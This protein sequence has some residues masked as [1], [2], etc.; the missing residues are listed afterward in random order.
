MNPLIMDIETL[1]AIHWTMERKAAYNVSKVPGN[2]KKPAT[3]QNWMATVG[4]TK[5]QDTSFSPEH[6]R[7]FCFGHRTRWTEAKVISIHH[8]TD[9]KELIG[10]IEE[11]VCTHLEQPDAVLVAHNGRSFD[12]PFLRIR[13]MV[14][15][16]H[17]LASALKPGKPWA[18]K[19]VDTC[20]TFKKACGNMTVSGGLTDMARLLGIEVMPTPGCP[21]GS[22]VYA[23]WNTGRM[24]DIVDHCTVDIDVLMAV[25]KRMEDCGYFNE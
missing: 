6:G 1:P 4:V 13:A 23:A 24:Q 10:K 15:G 18:T 12:Y 2:Y 3:I 7:V 16:Y 20:D 9:E 19:L 8:A 11:V 5:W 17:R 14:H 21:D 22:H 25:F